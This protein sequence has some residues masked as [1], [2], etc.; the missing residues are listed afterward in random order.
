M[1]DIPWK[2]TEEHYIR[3]SKERLVAK[4]VSPARAEFIV[5]AVNAYNEELPAA[6]SVCKEDL[7]STSVRVK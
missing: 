3:D 7:T 2:V 5:Q 4:A 1:S 6:C